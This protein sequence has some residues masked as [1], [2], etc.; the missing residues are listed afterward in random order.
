MS[1]CVECGDVELFFVLACGD[2]AV[3]ESKILLYS[4]NELR[5]LKR[6]IL[7]MDRAFGALDRA[8]SSGNPEQVVEAQNHLA[9]M[10]KDYI[11]P[12]E[13]LPTRH[14]V[15]TYSLSGKKWTRIR[16]DK[17]RNHWRSY[18]IDRALL[19]ALQRGDRS[20]LDRVSLR[21]AFTSA[22]RKIRDDLGQGITFKGQLARGQVSGS[23]SDL[24]DNSFTQWID[25]VNDSLTFSDAG[26]NHDLSAGAQLMR[27]YAGFGAQLGYD[28]KKSTY[29]LSGNAEARAIL[30][31]AKAQFDGYV[32][33]RDGWHAMIPFQSTRASDAGRYQELN[34]GYFRGRLTIKASAM[35]GASIYG[36]AGIEYKKAGNILTVMPAAADAKGEIAVGAFAG[37]EA[38]GSATGAAEWRN[39]GIIDVQ[40]QQ[41]IT[42]AGWRELF[43]VGATGM[44]SA[45]A[46]AEANFRITYEGDKFMFRCEARLVWGIGAKGGIEGEVGLGAIREFVAYVYHQLKDNDFAFLDFI[47]QEAFNMIVGLLLL[48]LD[49]GTELAQLAAAPFRAAVNAIRADFANA[50]E[51]EA[52]A[53][54]IKARPLELIFSPPEVKGAVLYRL[55][56]TF[57]SSREE[58]QEAAILAVVSTM[59]SKREWEQVQERITPTGTKTT[60]AAGLAR[61][62]YILDGGSYREFQR[63]HEAINRLPSRTLA[64][65][66]PVLVQQVQYA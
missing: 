28:P 34:F 46:G 48:A 27:A 60:A 17:M 33:H 26:A 5:E 40:S 36:T 6:E 56:Q 63:L 49:R 66:A 12:S 15:Q 11:D 37:V 55:S 22:S 24:W 14:V 51:A 65:G 13:H 45:G 8:T 23:V 4:G 64:Y 39:P 50:A 61:L 54:R 7:E 19:R 35:L 16:S 57:W 3:G 41:E 30:G 31:E 42:P 43:K 44:A 62:R 29:G 21:N 18:P 47:A 58:H 53:R 1:T 59:Q 38:G 10:L 25:A 2:S 20:Q 52:Y 32:P 9:E